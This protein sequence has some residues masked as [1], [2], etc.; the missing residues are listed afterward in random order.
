MHMVQGYFISE[1]TVPGE[2]ELGKSKL[3]VDLS[4]TGVNTLS[5]NKTKGWGLKGVQE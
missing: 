4:A 1:L 5:T 3:E 2:E